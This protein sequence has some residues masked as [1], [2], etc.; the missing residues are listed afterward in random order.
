MSDQYPQYPPGGSPQP[1]G[2][3]GSPPPYGNPP[4]PYGQPSQQPG[5][6]NPPSQYG[7]PPQQS[8]YGNPPAPATYGQPQPGG[9]GAPPPP[10]GA[11]PGGPGYGEAPPP[12]PKKSRTS[13]WVA[14]GVILL[15]VIGGGIVLYTTL[16]PSKE[17]QAERTAHLSAPAKIG[18]LALQS[19]SSGAADTEN[20]FKD[21]LDATAKDSVSGIYSDPADPTK[22][23][24]LVAATADLDNPSKQLDSIFADPTATITNIHSVSA[25]ALSGEARCA[26]AESDG[27]KAIVCAWADHGSVG[28][29]FLF[30]RAAAESE[31]LFRQIRAAVLTRG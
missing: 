23:V 16:K 25:G 5:Y 11:G 19:D 21:E 12:P 6:G 24:L 4:S 29:V 28:A 31:D 26:D 8:G 14:I 1:G 17:T 2:T 3:Y 30:N 20:S 27:N 10:Y 9:Y 22:I 13:L 15:L 18:T 7:P